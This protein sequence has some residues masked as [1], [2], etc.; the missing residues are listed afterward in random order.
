M[1]RLRLWLEVRPRH[2][3]VFS[4]TIWVLTAFLSSSRAFFLRSLSFAC[5]SASSAVFSSSDFGCRLRFFV[6]VFDAFSSAFCFLLSSARAFFFCF[7]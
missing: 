1:E 2:A 6:P 5:F 7:Y 4:L 3:H